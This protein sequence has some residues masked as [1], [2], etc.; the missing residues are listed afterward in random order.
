M[1]RKSIKVKIAG[2]AGLALLFLSIVLISYSATSLRTTALDSAKGNVLNLAKS[3]AA[4][5]KT[6]VEEAFDSA[7]TLAY[8]LSTVADK[9]LFVALAREDVN[10]ILKKVLQDNPKFMGTY[11]L[12]EPD[13][14]DQED[15][16]HVDEEGH[17]NTG[18]YIPYWVRDESGNIIVKPLE[19]YNTSGAGDYYL[20]PKKSKKECI[21]DPR[22]I[23]GKDM[24]Y[25]SLVVP[26]VE[27]GSFFG[28][29][30]ID[31]TLEFIQKLADE[32]DIYD[33]SGDFIL[34]SNSGIISAVTGKRNLLGKPVGDLYKNSVNVM[35]YVQGGIEILEEVD[36]DISVFVPVNFGKSDTPWSVNITIPKEKITEVASGMM[37]RLII[38][39]LIITLVSLAGIYYLAVSIA[40]PFRKILAR[41]NTG[42]E[43]VSFVSGEVSKSSQS[44]AEGATEQAS[45]LENSSAALEEMTS[46]I[47][48]NSDNA[49][50]ASTMM[51]E[52]QKVVE[53]VEKRMNEMVNAIDEIKRS[54][55]ETSA[56]IK[57]IEE[58]AFQTNLLA[59]N[60]AV[61]AARAGE[62]GRGF[63]VVAEEVRS[64]AGRSAE[65]AKNTSQ[66]IENTVKAVKN[67]DNIT[68]E[69]LK[70]FN[71]NAALSAKIVKLIDEIAVA[72]R[73]Q[74]EG[75]SQVN[76]GVSEMDKMVQENVSIAEKSAS[77]SEEMT[78]QAENMK[79]M[80]LDLVVLISGTG[81]V[82]GVIGAGDKQ[83]GKADSFNPG[84]FSKPEHA[85]KSTG[86]AVKKVEMKNEN[87]IPLDEDF[88]EF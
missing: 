22:N 41:I 55:G 82:N 76:S 78:S 13:A 86:L 31:I 35:G 52:S 61:E 59:L 33:R 38:I 50:E 16:M 64:L 54:S 3:Q 12:W 34:I 46:M 80:I 70:S 8:V 25:A 24:I 66:L 57:T 21:I 20:K 81:T 17:D 18:R 48:Q 84:A 65:A 58:I 74:S 56:I 29:A 11:T 32:I 73:E 1:E 88:E 49:G 30:G 75:V 19:N 72:S 53:N 77:A 15:E 45:S 27:D 4:K 68:Q 71:E 9:D 39:G 5:I 63:A 85:H 69:T 2:W 7:R 44:A 87:I 26:I 36:G 14:F 43:Q 37:W 67:G 83:N 6:E 23:S 40:N 51:N 62:A 28:I 47:K 10:A 60:A 42:A 79:T